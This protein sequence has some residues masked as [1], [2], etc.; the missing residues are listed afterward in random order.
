MRFDQLTPEQQAQARARFF[1]AGHGDGYYYFVS[2]D[3]TVLCRNRERNA[4][5]SPSPG[6][7]A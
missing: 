1:N 2:P 4:N 3:G 5:V 7:A 6:A